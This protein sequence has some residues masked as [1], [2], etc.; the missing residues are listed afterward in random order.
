MMERIHTTSCDTMSWGKIMKKFFVLFLVILF[1]LSGFVTQAAQ[2]GP[3]ITSFT[4]TATTVDR[5][6]LTN[7]TARI[8]VSWTTSNRPEGSNLVFE[9]ALPD[10][11]VLNVELPRDN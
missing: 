7:R 2:N 6:A 11:R 4:S 1:S 8:P 5:T 3:Q 10:G 9:Q